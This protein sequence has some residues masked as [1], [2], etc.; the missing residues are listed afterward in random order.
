RA[1]L[2]RRVL[3]PYVFGYLALYGVTLWLLQRSGEEVDEMVF[4]LIIFGGIFPALTWLVTRRAQPLPVAVRRPGL[5]TA[6]IVGYML[7]VFAYLIWGVG[8]LKALVTTEPAQDVTMLV[9]K[10]VVWV[11]IPAALLWLASG[12]SFRDLVPL[13]GRNWAATL[14]LVVAIMALQCVA[15]RGLKDMKASGYTAGTLALWAPLAYAWLMVEVGVVEEFFFRAVLQTRIARLLRSDAGG[16]VIAS[17]LFGLVHAPG[18]YLRTAASQE[19]LGT[20][21]SILMAVGYSLVVTS[22]AGIFL[23]VLW[24]RTRNFAAVVLVHAAGDLVPGLVP[25]IHSFSGR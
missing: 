23:G 22:A 12:Y 15:G 8:A 11:A 2:V 6:I 10:L 13:S 18:F 14:V 7:P 4:A 1:P 24:S 16:V 17:V 9:A 3:D 19:T 21:P 5:E 20:H 25:F